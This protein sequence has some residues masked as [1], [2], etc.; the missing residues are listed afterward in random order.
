MAKSKV[1]LALEARLVVAAQVYRDQKQRIA[2]LESL[3]ATRGHI[4]TVAHAPVPVV[5]EF[6]KRDGSRWISTRIGNRTTTRAIE[7][8]AC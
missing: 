6:A 2:E 5:R 8:V 3:L 4:A 1:V 7:S